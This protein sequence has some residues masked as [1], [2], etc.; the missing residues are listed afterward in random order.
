MGMQAMSL[1]VWMWIFN[2]NL[3]KLVSISQIPTVG[4]I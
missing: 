1:L 2:I 3:L 4:A